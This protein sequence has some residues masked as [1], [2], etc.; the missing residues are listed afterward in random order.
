MLI[1]RVINAQKQFV[2]GYIIQNGDTIKGFVYLREG[3]QTYQFCDFKIQRDTEG[4][5]YTAKDINGYGYINDRSYLSAPIKNEESKEENFFIQ[6]YIRGRISM[7]RLE[8]D[9]V[10]KKDSTFHLLK[11]SKELIVK[12]NEKYFK[13]KKEYLGLISYLTNDCKGASRIPLKEL[14][15]SLEGIGKYIESYNKCINPQEVS[16]LTKKPLFSLSIGLTLSSNIQKFLIGEEPQLAIGNELKPDLAQGI[17]IPLHLYLSKLSDRF[18]FS[19]EPQFGKTSIQHFNSAIIGGNLT[20]LFLEINYN[21]IKVPLGLRYRHTGKR[22]VPNIGVGPIKNFIV[23][24]KQKWSRDIYYPSSGTFQSEIITPFPILKKY[25]GLWGSLGVEGKVAQKLDAFAE[26]R[27][28]YGNGLFD[29][30]L[31][32]AGD[33]LQSSKNYQFTIGIKT[34]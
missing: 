19:I 7:Y 10:L 14:S 25:N 29:V 31:Y 32:S 13:E 33:Q 18:A 6:E 34:R 24:E 11:N 12:G 15:Y 28:E 27:F 1:P 20:N 16:S 4:K 26:F 30:F 3:P 23:N 9:F 21:F 5:R 22:I 2:E 8:T 17:G